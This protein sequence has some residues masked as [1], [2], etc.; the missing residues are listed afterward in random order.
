M[1]TS[2]PHVSD[3]DRAAFD[4]FLTGADEEEAVQ[5]AVRLSASGVT[6]EELL[7]DLVTPAQVAVGS[8]WAAGEW[9]IAQE[10]AAT[11]I[12][13]R[14][15]DAVAAAV[16]ATGAESRTGGPGAAGE[17]LVACSDG[18]WHS[19]SARIL[20]VVL[21]LRGFRVRFLGGHVPVA[22]L[23]A[24]MHQNDPDVVALSCTLTAHLPFAYRQIE[25]CRTAGVPVLAGG[26]GFG[27]EGAWAYALGADLYSSDPASAAELLRRRW[28]PLLTGT[29]SVQEASV[30]AYARLV[31]QRPELLATV[32]SRLAD[33]YPAPHARGPGKTEAVNEIPGHLLDALAAAVFVDDPRAL[34][35]YLSYATDFLA[36]RGVHDS[37]VRLTLD[38]VAEQ[39]RDS[40]RVLAHVQ[41]GQRWLDGQLVRQGL[42][43]SGP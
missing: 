26:H 30:E 24:D 15:V 20:A 36:A 40:P 1:N 19:L 9:T 21:R 5:L 29:P 16:G 28:P 17:V 25:M 27:P 10:H 12:S 33:R 13:E 41:E 34:T 38:T 11:H 2:R 7:L 42:S 43:P 18:E 23:L 3:A 8:R 39:L 22:R 6:A 32:R 35:G 14:C 37:R 31:R 4:D